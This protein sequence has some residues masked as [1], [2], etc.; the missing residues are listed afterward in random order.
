MES[1]LS[2]PVSGS[3]RSRLL[4]W[5]LAGVGL[6]TL[7]CVLGGFVFLTTGGFFDEPH[8]GEGE[9]SPSDY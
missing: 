9:M 5:I 6:V 3:P 4:I 7:I 2:E 8:C 1:Q